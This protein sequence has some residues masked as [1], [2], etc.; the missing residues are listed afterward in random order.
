[1]SQDASTR[2][3]EHIATLK[4]WRGKLIA[5]LR[6]V[7]NS[8]DP[9]LQEDWKW[10]TPVWTAR[11]NICAIGAFK[12][13]VKINFFKGA[14]L[15]DPHHLFNGGLEAKASRSIDL[16]QRDSL[17]EAALTELVRAAVAMHAKG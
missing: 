12:E 13:S 17:N 14:T 16:A 8:A 2:I 15:P 1:M 4:D 10:G 9:G 6:E 7:I 11:G 5:R 3:D